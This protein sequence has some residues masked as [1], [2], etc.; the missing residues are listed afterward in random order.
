MSNKKVWLFRLLSLLLDRK[1][2]REF[3]IN[4][5]IPIHSKKQHRH[6][7]KNHNLWKS[8][9]SLE[10]HQ[11]HHHK[12]PN[13]N[14]CPCLTSCHSKP[15]KSMMEMRII[16]FQWIFPQD[17]NPIQSNPY[18]IKNRKRKRNNQGSNLSTSSH[19]QI[20]ERKPKKHNPNISYQPERLKLNHRINHASYKQEKRQILNHS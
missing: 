16:S 12:G 5:Q 8:I 7:H 20:S 13:S 9:C 1:S 2:T 10:Q 19:S 11:H 17:K 4:K 15:Q 3:F 14:K 18:R 6:H